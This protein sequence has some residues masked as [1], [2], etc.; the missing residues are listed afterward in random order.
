MGGANPTRPCAYTRGR[1]TY[2]HRQGWGV[3]LPRR[4]WALLGAGGA[5]SCGR[6]CGCWGLLGF[7]GYLMG[8]RP[9]GAL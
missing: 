2:P 4:V 8:E 1:A 7:Q 6:L 3:W 9:T 5:G